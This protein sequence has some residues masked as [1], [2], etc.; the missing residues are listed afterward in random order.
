M[1]A[2]LRCTMHVVTSRS[3]RDHP[4]FVPRRLPSQQTIMVYEFAPPICCPV[5]SHIN[6]QNQT[7][8]AG[9]LYC[10]RHM[11][12]MG[13]DDMEGIWMEN[14]VYGTYATHTVIYTWM[15]P[16]WMVHMS[17]FRLESYASIDA[18]FG[19]F[20]DKIYTTLSLAKFKFSCV[21]MRP[22]R[23]GEKENRV[24]FGPR[25]SLRKKGFS[26]SVL[27]GYRCTLLHILVHHL[28]M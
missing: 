16:Q 27:G 3:H 1:N 4:S 22:M 18:L 11:A 26:S 13:M 2:R 9:I 28:A 17:L 14:L 21:W 24:L 7:A 12:W 20:T 19:V 5:F 6:F 15:G 23:S 10:H 8:T 25:V